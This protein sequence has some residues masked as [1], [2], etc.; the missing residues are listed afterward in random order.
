MYVLFLD[1]VMAA[2]L[3]FQIFRQDPSAFLFTLSIDH[4]AKTVAFEQIDLEILEKE[5]GLIK[6]RGKGIQF[7][8]ALLLE[9]TL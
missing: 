7:I 8:G 5:A 4:T 2:A 3:F 6:Y 9:G 1:K